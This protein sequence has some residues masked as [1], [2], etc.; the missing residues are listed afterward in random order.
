MWRRNQFVCREL[1]SRGWAILFVEPA[2]DWSAGLRHRRWE[3]FARRRVWSP[4]GLPGVSVVRPVKVLPKQWSAG[5]A[6]NRRLWWAAVSGAMRKSGWTEPRRDGE[7]ARPALWVNNQMLWPVASGAA[8]GAWGRVVY[9]VTDDWTTG[10]PDGRTRRRIEAD[11]R[12][13]CGHADEVIVCSERLRDLKAPLAR[14]VHLIPNGVDLATYRRVGRDATPEAA[15]GWPGPVLGYTGTLHPERFD[16]RLL[17]E[18]AASW[19]GTVALVGPSHLG[20]AAR[21]LRS[22]RNVVFVGGVAHD[23]LPGWMSAMD[24]MIVPHR[25]TEFT[26]SL[27]PLKLW[28]YLA[29]GR[30]VVSTPVAGF[31]DYAQHVRLAEDAQTFLAACRDALDEPPDRAD[32]R[33]SAAEAHGWSGRVDQIERVLRNVEPK[34]ASEVAVVA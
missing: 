29:A 25:V 2:A 15:R 31:R 3:Q 13:M 8:R 12:A 20:E 21:G 6:G 16:T 28:E 1:A 19:P 22:M 26:E 24:V 30:P 4:E 5:E 7:A 18:V 32:A 9:D 33:R 11:D 17:E 14:R 23:A 34:T 10:F 27:N